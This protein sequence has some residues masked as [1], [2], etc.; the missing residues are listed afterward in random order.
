[1]CLLLLSVVFSGDGSPASLWE[2]EEHWCVQL[3][4]PA[5]GETSCSVQGAPCC[6]SGTTYLAPILNISRVEYV[7]SK[8]SFFLIHSFFCPFWT[9]EEEKEKMWK[10]GDALVGSWI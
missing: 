6:Q 1:M 4:H 10:S 8:L 2:S 5:A 3:Q 9:I 7:H